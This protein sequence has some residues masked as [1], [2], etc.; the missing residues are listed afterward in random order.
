M[1]SVTSL[2]PDWQRGLHPSHLPHLF[3]LQKD[4]PLTGGNKTGGGFSSMCEVL[5]YT[6]S[7]RLDT[8]LM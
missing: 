5:A 7:Y 3:R 8:V 6:D 1:V 2:G 4:L